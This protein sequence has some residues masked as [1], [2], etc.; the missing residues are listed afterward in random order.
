LGLLYG[1]LPGRSAICTLRRIPDLLGSE[2][3]GTSVTVW[4]RS[5]RFVAVGVLV[6]AM[7]IAP[8]TADAAPVGDRGATGDVAQ[9]AADGAPAGPT[10][11]DAEPPAFAA[12]TPPQPVL[13]RPY[14]FQ[15]GLS[16][17]TGVTF[18]VESGR[19]PEGL[20]LS[21]AGLLA[22]TPSSSTF[23]QV[24]VTATNTAGSSDKPIA[25]QSQ[26]VDVSTT[27][28][29]ATD[30]Y[31]LAD[32]QVTTGY[33]DGSYG[34]GRPIT[35][36]AFAAFLY[37]YAHGGR[38]A[39][40]CGLSGSPFP[41]VPV[42]NQFCGDI[43]WLATQNITQGYGDGKFKPG[44]QISRQA[45][46]AFLYRMH[47]DGEDA[48]P[49]ADSAPFRD[50]QGNQFCGDVAWL[51]S[52]APVPI[53]AGYADG[54]FRPAKPV[55][56]QAMAAFL[57]RYDTDFP[58]SG[59]TAAPAE[60]T[61]VLTDPADVLSMTGSPG[62][63][64]QV[65]L[66]P[67]AAAF[68]AIDG[69]LVAPMSAAAPDGVLLTV[70]D[71]TWNDDGS[72]TV[73]GTP[74]TLDE[75]YTDVDIRA[76]A[77]GSLPAA[78]AD[79]GA[80]P[81]G[82]AAHGSTAVSDEEPGETPCSG[83]AT[84]HVHA[85]VDYGRHRFYAALSLAR[86]SFVMGGFLQPT[87]TLDATFHGEGTC[88]LELDDDIVVPLSAAPPLA[89]VLV[90]TLTV[91]AT[92]DV[93]ATARYAPQASLLI[94]ESSTNHYRRFSI[95]DTAPSLSASGHATVTVTLSM[96]ARLMLAGR[97][98]LGGGIAPS[99]T[100]DAS[101]QV[102]DQGHQQNCI[103]LTGQVD[104]SLTATMDLWIK[105][106]SWTLLS[107]T[108]GKHQMY[109]R[110]SATAPGTPPTG[111]TGG[112]SVRDPG[113][114][115]SG[116]GGTGTP[117]QPPHIVTDTVPAAKIAKQYHATLSATG[118][119]TPYRWERWA[120]SLPPGLAIDMDTG[121]IDGSPKRAGTYRFTVQVTTWDGLT[122]SH[123]Y[124][125]AVAGY[126]VK[127]VLGNGADCLGWYYF[128][129]GSCLRTGVPALQTSL[130]SPDGHGYLSTSPEDIQAMA[131]APD[132]TLYLW[133]SGRIFRQAPG[134]GGTF[135]AVTGL[136]DLAV[137]TDAAPCR[138]NVPATTLVVEAYAMAV[139][140]AGNLYVADAWN[141]LVYRITPGGTAA[142]VAGLAG[143]CEGN[144][145]VDSGDGG[146]ATAAHLRQP[147]SLAISPTG[148]VYVSTLGVQ[149]CD[150]LG[151]CHYP[152]G[153]VRAFTP[154]GTISTVLTAD[155]LPDRGY[156]GDAQA[157]HGTL[158]A[159]NENGLYV[160]ST[161]RFGG[162]AGV[163]DDEG[164]AVFP[165]EPRFLD[166]CLPQ[167][168]AWC[169]GP[170]TLMTSPHH[171]VPVQCGRGAECSGSTIDP[172]GWFVS[173]YPEH[174]NVRS[175]AMGPDG[176]LFVGTGTGVWQLGPSTSWEDGMP[177]PG[178]ALIAGRDDEVAGYGGDSGPAT[179]ALFDTISSL[180]AA[181]DG[182]VYVYDTVNRRVRQL[183]PPS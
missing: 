65:V 111:G 79:A 26:F 32:R 43:A 161:G 4:L 139:D 150:D 40:D 47:H 96:E 97:V 31:W 103:D 72:V 94:N 141:D 45:M 151:D 7:V 3:E 44:R 108:F 121:G 155:E 148:T 124:T 98:G 73:T 86:R 10:E 67:T 102:D 33:S 91:H 173:G 77:D 114:G 16:A 179:D 176:E 156:N 68:P 57:H 166:V 60:A 143:D 123:D 144:H 142:I 146:P 74:A 69:F 128:G 132:G 112:D 101:I 54:T 160:F 180:A 5:G 92:G 6:A 169:Y 42:R 120:G 39:G 63:S 163:F 106:W 117:P 164:Q 61:T 165:W 116:G 71:E 76:T 95:S 159:A 15:F 25:L 62:G 58:G 52:T 87:I 131:L 49:C 70:T 38:D 145:H 64:Q 167:Y 23:S 133:N 21:A 177:A 122:D 147:H 171:L 174:Y 129:P 75:A 158:L 12:D 178:A 125:I 8:A 99:L 34:A 137:P 135:Q 154:G 182:S 37:R 140:A 82:S 136:P 153:G 59:N 78:T 30:I 11:Q 50:V 83:D 93:V 100:L 27:A 46:A 152:G 119:S 84:A 126:R 41:D 90:P 36:A 17:G 66:G 118:G 113:S 134:V 162:A 53:V 149:Q 56:R 48:G 14:A 168:G 13:G 175:F 1:S 157:P 183:T 29:F 51:T 81:A 110:C 138:T 170:L 18:A 105:D 104:M 181:A 115:G 55:S 20:T 107:G 85:D 24:V 28:A 89:L 88:V 22:G 9:Q 80:A 35:R 172:P 19:L 127:T 2:S 130:G 109:H